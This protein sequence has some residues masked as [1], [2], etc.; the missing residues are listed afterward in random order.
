MKAEIGGKRIGDGNNMEVNLK[1][2]QRSTHN[3]NKVVRTSMA[4]GTLVPVY[5][6]IALPG[7]KWEIDMN[8]FVRTLPT[9]SALYGSFKM[10]VDLF[11]CPMRLY[12][13]QLHNNELGIGMKMENVKFPQIKVPVED[14]DF[15]AESINSQQISQSS[16]LA[17]LGIR[18]LG[19][20]VE[21]NT[22]REL[23][24]MPLLAYWD[25]YKNYYAN[26]QEEVGA[27]ID[28]EVK[29]TKPM[30]I[31]FSKETV[32]GNIVRLTPVVPYELIDHNGTYIYQVILGTAATATIGVEN[33]ADEGGSYQRN[34][35]LTEIFEN[36]VLEKSTEVEV[37]IDGEKSK[38]TQLQYR[39][40]TLKQDFINAFAD[41]ANPYDLAF[42]KSQ[43]SS[44]DYTTFNVVV[45]YQTKD[46]IVYNSEPK[47]NMFELS[48]IDDMRDKILRAEKGTPLYLEDGVQ[49]PYAESIETIKDTKKIRAVNIMNGLGI[50]TYQSDRFNNWLSTEW[51]DGDNGIAAITSV[52]TQDDSFTIDSLIFAKHVY[53]MLNRIAISGG[54]YNDWVESMYGRIAGGL[55]ESPVYQG[56]ISAYVEFGE[57]VSTSESSGEPLGTIGGR[58]QREKQKGGKIKINVKEPSIIIAIASITPLIDYSQ[59]NAWMNR[60]ETMDDLHK[61][62]MDGIGFQELITDEMVAWDT[63]VSGENEIKYNSVGKQPAYIEY[64]TDVNEVFGTFA[65]KG[66]ESFMVLTRNY[67]HDTDGK[68]V[69]ATTYI[70]PSKHNYAFAVT[71]LDAQN[72]WTQIKLDIKCRR[73]MS[74]KQIPTL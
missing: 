47:I 9:I 63:E 32:N 40:N 54:S 22:Y 27:V 20:P 29:Y 49:S 31:Q 61:P 24:A 6:N 15:T 37:E 53:N 68:F 21:A 34:W 46:F 7:D 12:N 28:T 67:E 62:A 16:L 2:Y 45:G 39:L 59:G 14:L 41:W 60:L 65:E 72:F 10:Q 48:H 42:N 30:P 13:A 56:G 69:D 66:S 18:G 17:Y 36:V 70:D 58:G 44:T 43:L 51:I 4:P 26:K 1:D 23:N 11:E 33:I 5:R 64:Q 57:V 38:Q 50:K 55:P 35:Y 71:R 3:L 8:T 73:V 74:A 19:K 52:S 25:I